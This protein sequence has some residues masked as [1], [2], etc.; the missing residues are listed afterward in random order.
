LTPASARQI[1]IPILAITGFYDG[2][3][4]GCLYNWQ[5]IEPVARSTRQR[6]HLI[7]GPWRH[8]QMSTGTSEPMGLVRFGGNANVSLPKT[9]LGFFDAYMK[10][11]RAALEQLPKRCRLYTSGS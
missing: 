7:I 8:A 1:E 6:R 5:T 9:V 10:D 2:D 11:D 4:A 3:Q